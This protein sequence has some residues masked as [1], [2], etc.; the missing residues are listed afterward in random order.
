MTATQVLGTAGAR[1][2]RERA[3]VVILGGGYG[4]QLAAQSVALRTDAAVT[5]V[6][7]GDR[8]VQRVRLH[9]LASGQPLSTRSGPSEATGGLSSP[10]R[11][12]APGRNWRR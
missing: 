9:Q 8:F 4:G 2:A 5:L 6:N 11:S 12:P 10:N 3:H 1:G 7:D